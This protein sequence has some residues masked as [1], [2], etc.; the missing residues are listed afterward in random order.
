MNDS[1]A[2]AEWDWQPRY[3]LT[4]MVRDMLEKIAVKL[5]NG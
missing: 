2:R 4:A 1:A 5:Q 3:D